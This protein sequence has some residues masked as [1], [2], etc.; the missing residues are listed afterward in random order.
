MTEKATDE[1][2]EIEY[3]NMVKK[4]AKLQ[5]GLEGL[6]L[7]ERMALAKKELEMEQEKGKEQKPKKTR[8]L[9][10]GQNSTSLKADINRIESLPDITTG[11]EE[12]DELVSFSAG[13]LNVFY[14]Y[15]GHGK[16]SFMLKLMQAMMANYS[17]EKIAC[18]YVLFEDV[19]DRL[20]GRFYKAFI[21]DKSQIEADIKIDEF[22]DNSSYCFESSISDEDDDDDII[23]DN[24]EEELITPF[25]ELNKGKTIVIFIDYIQQIDGKEKNKNAYE[26]I[27]ALS[28]KL[29]R[30]ATKK[31]EEIIIIAGAQ[32]NKDGGL[33]EADDIKHSADNIIR[34]YNVASGMAEKDK[35]YKPDTLND[36]EKQTHSEFEKQGYSL[37]LFHI[38][39]NRNKGYKGGCKNVFAFNGFNFIECKY[40]AGLYIP[41]LKQYINEIKMKERVLPNEVKK[42]HKKTP[43]Y[44]D[45]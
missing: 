36:L 7:Q 10:V 15:S 5:H 25:K 11:F 17:S 39:K 45:G 20:K 19:K 32:E 38:I 37:V 40:N 1:L 2:D 4:I 22:A 24:L 29:K 23:I 28:K 6:D 43:R 31:N 27:K 35:N 41:V 26:K 34:L 8:K 16:T 33:R 9:S 13:T 3:W 21:A 14:A 12:L 30:I 42:S 44:S 18:M